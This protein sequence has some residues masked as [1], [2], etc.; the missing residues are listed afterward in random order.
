MKTARNETKQKNFDKIIMIQ[1]VSQ[2]GIKHTR[3]LENKILLK[4]EAFN[5]SALKI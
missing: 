1:E 2:I 4:F 3:K 5:L